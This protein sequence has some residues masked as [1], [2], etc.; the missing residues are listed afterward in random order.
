[1]VSIN[2]ER[3]NSPL[4]ETLKQSG[5]SVSST[6]KLTSVFNSLKSL[7]L[8]CLD[9]KN[10]PSVPASGESFTMK[11][12]EIVGSLILWNSIGVKSFVSVIVSPICKSSIPV[13]A[14]IEPSFASFTSTLSSPSNSYSFEIFIFSFLFAS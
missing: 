10:F 7:S 2:I 1:M 13:T 12:I 4:P 14:T 6:L 11:Y 5:E 9:V 3:C 8:I